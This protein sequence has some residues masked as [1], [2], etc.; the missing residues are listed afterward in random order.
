MELFTSLGIY[1]AK[2]LEA[3]NEVKWETYSTKVLI[4][5]R[6]AA[7]MAVNHIL[8][9]G[10]EYQKQLLESLDLMRQNYPHDW[11]DMALTQN[12]LIR[13]CSAL[14]ADIKTRTDLLNAAREAAEAEED[15]LAKAVQAEKAAD[16]LRLLRESIDKLEEITDNALWP[17]PKYRELLFIN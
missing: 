16:A 14:I 8:P 11:R 6:M 4:E 1:S 12:G 10:V 9:A 5:A 3:R 15:A 2:E 17:L 13:E 7:R